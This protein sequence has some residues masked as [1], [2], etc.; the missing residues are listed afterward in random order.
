MYNKIC[1]GSNVSSL[2]VSG[3]MYSKIHNVLFRMY[4]EICKGSD[5]SSVSV[6]VRVRFA[7]L[8]LIQS[9]HEG[10]L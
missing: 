3:M 5:V 8:Y 7:K 1:N 9:V 2:S 6:S 4:N 10:M